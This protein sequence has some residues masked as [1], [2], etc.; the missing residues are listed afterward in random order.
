MALLTAATRCQG[1]ALVAVTHDPGRRG[2]L[3]PSRHHS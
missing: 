3:R 2:G 1:T